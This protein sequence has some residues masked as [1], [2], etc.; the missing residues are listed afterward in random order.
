M[1]RRN[2]VAAN[3][4]F[5]IIQSPS[6]FQ[7]LSNLQRNLSM[8]LPKEMARISVRAELKTQKQGSTCKWSLQRAKFRGRDPLDPWIK[9]QISLQWLVK[10]TGW[11]SLQEDDLF[12]QRLVC[13]RFKTR[14]CCNCFSLT[15]L[16][17]LTA[18]FTKSQVRRGHEGG[19]RRR[20][21]SH[22]W[23]QL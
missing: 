17:K 1:Y 16:S 15:G 20:M 11:K 18:A 4:L 21:L 7:V 10:T 13:I 9:P 12:I 14:L 23:A 8:L 19:A 2:S 3:V 6:V 22:T 5:A